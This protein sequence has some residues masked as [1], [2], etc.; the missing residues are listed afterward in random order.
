MRAEENHPALAREQ[1]EQRAKEQP[2]ADVQ[3]RKRLVQHQQVGVVQQGG[4]Q[5]HALPH[6]FGIRRQ[7][8]IAAVEEREQLEE[9]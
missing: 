5:K 1:V 6:A 8:A 2:G 7:R 9:S 4:R 3:A